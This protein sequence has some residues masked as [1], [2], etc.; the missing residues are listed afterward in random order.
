MNEKM[1][2]TCLFVRE[3]CLCLFVVVC[4]YECVCFMCMFMNLFVCDDFYRSFLRVALRV[5]GTVWPSSKY[6]TI[7]VRVFRSATLFR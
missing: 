3:C 2:I 6:I 1:I 5:L 4:V 7:S